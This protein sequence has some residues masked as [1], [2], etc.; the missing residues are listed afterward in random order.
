MALPLSFSHTK[1]VTSSHCLMNPGKPPGYSLRLPCVGYHGEW[2]APPCLPAKHGWSSWLPVLLA[3]AWIPDAFQPHSSPKDEYAP[4][5]DRYGAVPHESTVAT[6]SCAGG[7]LNRGGGEGGQGSSKLFSQGPP[8]SSTGLRHLTA[9][10]AGLWYRALKR[11]DAGCI[12][13]Q[14]QNAGGQWAM[15]SFGNQGHC[16]NQQWM[17]GQLECRGL[18][19]VTS[20]SKTGT[21]VGEGTKGCSGG[22][23]GWPKK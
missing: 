8:S 16:Q 23:K 4:H 20:I 17:V 6:L 22:S 11:T 9:S 13:S 15:A 1:Y 18:E 21:M 12:K 19:E 14:G 5:Q 2:K 10:W 7:L 3:S